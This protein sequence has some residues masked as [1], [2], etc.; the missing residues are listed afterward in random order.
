MAVCLFNASIDAVSEY[1]VAAKYNL[2]NC[3]NCVLFL[4]FDNC[5]AAKSNHSVDHSQ[6][7]CRPMFGETVKNPAEN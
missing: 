4:R 6:Y 5:I 2:H 3:V 1:F 7:G